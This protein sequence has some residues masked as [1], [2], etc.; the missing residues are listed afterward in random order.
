MSRALPVALVL[1]VLAFGTTAFLAHGDE[2]IAPPSKPGAPVDLENGTC[3]VKG[4]PVVEGVTDTVNGAIVHFCCPQCIPKYRAN[5][6]AYEANL[7]KDADVARRLD[8]VA[9]APPDAAGSPAPNAP[10]TPTAK[11]LAFHDAMRDAWTDHV[12][13]TR[14]FLVSAVAD[15]PDKTAATNRL[16]RNQDDLGNAIRP[17]YGD[18]ASTRLT[19][20]LKD[21]IAKAADLVTALEAND[22]AKADAARAAWNANAD[23]IAAFLHD[24]NPNAWSLDAAKSMLH[25]HLDVT[26]KEVAARLAS[27][28]D[29]DVA[30]YDRVRRQALEMADMLSDGIRRQFPEK[31]R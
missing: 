15:L 4:R 23:E 16:M 5:P 14:L 24:A 12:E 30:A 22:S 27:D 6:A 9:K 1:G 10:L 26:A 3:P 17:Y 2:P 13:W 19:S 7:R 20:L 11:G 18:A 21:H 25:E 29:A 8:S 28:W 31:F